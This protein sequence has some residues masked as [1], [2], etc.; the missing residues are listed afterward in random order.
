MRNNT[1]NT[2]KHLWKRFQKSEEPHYNGRMYIQYIMVYSGFF[3]C[4]YRV[5][6]FVLILNEAR[7]FAAPA[8]EQNL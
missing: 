6:F 5:S 4:F 7:M 8:I 3:V 2:R 1:I